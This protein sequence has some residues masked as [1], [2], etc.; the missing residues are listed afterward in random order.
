VRRAALT[1]VTTIVGLVLLLQFKTHPAGSTGSLVDLAA[2]NRA[3][4]HRAQQP[5]PTSTP[6]AHHTATH[7]SQPTKPVQPRT[8]T[9]TGQTVQTPYGPV[10][11]KIVENAGALTDVVALQL[12]G[13]NPRSTEIAA[14][15]T[16]IL[17]SEALRANSA[18]IHVVSGAT[19]TSDGYAQ[20]LQSAIDNA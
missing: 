13:G 18:R 15:A 14:G 9:S 16:P 8:V 1:I 4:H 2:G 20:S 10:Q 7:S 11:V 17:R 3:N 19:Y 6:A 5:S 12:P